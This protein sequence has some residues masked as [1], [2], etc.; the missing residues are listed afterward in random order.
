MSSTRADVIVEDLLGVG[1]NFN[2]TGSSLREERDQSLEREVRNLTNIVGQLTHQMEALSNENHRLTQ[3]NERSRDRLRGDN[4]RRVTI[5]DIQ[6]LS[7]LQNSRLRVIENAVRGQPRSIIRAQDIN[8]L[9]LSELASFKVRSTLDRFI[10]KIEACARGEERLTLAELKMSD[11]VGSIVAA[12]RQKKGVQEWDDFKKMLYD[13][14]EVKYDPSMLMQRANARFHYTID[15]DP[16]RFALSVQGFFTSVPREGL[17]NIDLAIKRKLYEGAPASVRQ[18]MIAF[19]DDKEIS[20]QEFIMNLE[21]YRSRYQSAT[22]NEKKVREIQEIA[23]GSTA[24]VGNPS[25]EPAWIKDVSKGQEAIVRAVE[26][27][28]KT[29]A[30]R[31]PRQERRKWCG[32]CRSDQHYVY[33]CPKSPPRGSCFDCLQMGHMKGAPGFPKKQQ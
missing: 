8:E 33:D 27:L 1:N 23:S 21:S 11:D 5:E 7:D 12:E 14:F 18:D 28:G 25:L 15:Q 2:Q 32:Y 22:A 30:G 10:K 13:L 19:M 9:S 16:I 4:S 29:M 17:P 24:Q 6:D 20:L 3:E 26:S 31:T